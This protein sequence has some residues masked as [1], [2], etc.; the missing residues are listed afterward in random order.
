LVFR[1]S[2]I[3]GKPSSSKALNNLKTERLDKP[4][5]CDNLLIVAPFG[6]ESKLTAFRNRIELEN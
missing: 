3:S 2:S 4:R 5:L 6:D 1:L